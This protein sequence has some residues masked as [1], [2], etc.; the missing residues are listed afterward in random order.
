MAVVGQLQVATNDCKCCEWV[1]TSRPASGFVVHGD[2]INS[3]QSLPPL[4][5]LTQHHR[6]HHQKHDKGCT[7]GG[8]SRIRAWKGPVLGSK[9]II[10]AIVVAV[11]FAFVVVGLLSTSMTHLRSCKSKRQNISLAMVTVLQELAAN[12]FT[13]A[14]TIW[15]Y[16]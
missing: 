4:S 10:V 13:I 11:D 5:L 6:K 3:S 9:I 16:M 1:I 14:M 2:N 15:L 12:Q 7:N 8:E